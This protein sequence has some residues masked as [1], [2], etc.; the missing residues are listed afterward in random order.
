MTSSGMLVLEARPLVLPQTISF[1]PPKPMK[2]KPL[3]LSLLL[4]LSGSASI[5]SSCVVPPPPGRATVGVGV[6]AGRVSFGVYDALPAGYTSPYYYYGNR[7]YWGGR[8]ETGRYV[9]HG[10]HYDGRYFHNGHYLYGGRYHGGGPV[11]HAG[12]HHR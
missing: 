5:L 1:A 12:R 10:R 9:Y 6:G 7:Y 8:W 11:A 2:T 4:G 3:F